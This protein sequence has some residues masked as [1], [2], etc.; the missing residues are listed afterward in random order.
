MSAVTN[1]FA[2]DVDTNNVT[3]YVSPSFTPVAGELLVIYALASASVAASPTLTASANGL[4]FSLLP[5]RAVYQTSADTLYAFVADQL[6]PGSPSA[7]TV[8]FTTSDAATGCILFGASVSGMTNTGTLAVRQAAKVDNVVGGTAP[9]TTFPVAALT[10][11]PTLFAQGTSVATGSTQPTGWTERADGTYSTP[12]RGGGYSSRDSGFT[13]TSITLGSSTNGLCCALALELD[14]SAG[15]SVTGT[16]TAT[17]PLVTAV[18]A[19]ASSDPGTLAASLPVVTASIA[20]TSRNPGT[21]AAAVPLAAAALTGTSRNS[22]T[23]AVAVP[24][25]TAAVTGTSRNPGTVSAAVPLVTAALLGTSRNPATL[26]STLPTLASAIAGTSRNPATLTAAL[27][28]LTAQLEDVTVV[29]GTLAASLPRLTAALTGSSRNPGTLDGTTPRATGALVGA[30]SNSA[31]M[32]ASLPL[33][34][35]AVEGTATNPGV[36]GAALPVLEA[37]IT[38]VTQ[39]P[40]D[41]SIEAGELYTGWAAGAAYVSWAARGPTGNP[42]TG[43]NVTTGWNAAPIEAHPMTGAPAVRSDWTAGPVTIGE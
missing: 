5:D 13:G 33:A 17:V 10:G 15:S 6:V 31:T 2:V 41:I 35:A 26:T 21:M 34:T 19:G 42:M 8:T 38:G 12:T 1:A 4:T 36:L 9:T 22:G 29:A 20:G 40:R 25:A 24:L 30:S 18:I 7:M 28:R 43:E 27:P 39:P 16:L 23:V 14:A 3:S 11:N 32:V 37:T